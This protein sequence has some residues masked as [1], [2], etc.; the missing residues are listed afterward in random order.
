METVV[1]MLHL[2]LMM[3]K[4]FT[5]QQLQ[6][7]LLVFQNLKRLKI[8]T[9]KLFLQLSKLMETPLTLLFKEKSTKDFYLD[10]KTQ[11][12]RRMF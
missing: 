7:E 6:M 9:E 4:Q 2:K 1:M 8:Q 10:S 12:T 11:L 3:Q 5:K